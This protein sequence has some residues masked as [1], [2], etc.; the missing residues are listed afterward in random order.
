MSVFVALLE[1]RCPSRPFDRNIKINPLRRG[2]SVKRSVISFKL[3]IAKGG[4]EA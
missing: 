3:K 1:P 4:K 2:F